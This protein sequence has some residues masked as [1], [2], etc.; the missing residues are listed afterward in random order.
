VFLCGVFQTKFVYGQEYQNDA[1]ATQIENAFVVHGLQN[2][3]WV[4]TF[5][6]RFVKDLGNDLLSIKGTSSFFFVCLSFDKNP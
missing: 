2:R 1:M 4:F 5:F 3:V 6:N